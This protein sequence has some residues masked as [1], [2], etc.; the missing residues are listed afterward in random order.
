MSTSVRSG[1]AV[2]VVVLLGSVAACSK[3][4]DAPTTTAA[5]TTTSPVQPLST[6]PAGGDAVAASFPTAQGLPFTEPPILTSTN[7]VLELTLDARKGTYEVGGV[8]VQGM[9][10]TGSFMGP[11]LVITPGDTL[12]FTVINN[13]GQNTNV[14]EHGFHVSPIGISDNVLRVMAPGS[15]SPVVVETTKDLTPGTYWYHTHLHGLTEAQVMAGLFGTLVVNGLSERLPG[16]LQEGLQEHLVALH[17]YQL[18][19]NNEVV[20]ENIDSNAPTTRMVN[21]M[22]NPVLTS[23]PGQTKLLRLANFSADIWYRLQMDGAKFSVLAEDANPVGRVEPRATLLLPPGKRFDVLVTWPKAGSYKL[24]TLR[25][26]Q[27]PEGDQYPERVLMTVN[28]SGSAVTTPSQPSSLAALP[29]LQNAEVAERRTVVFS[30]DNQAGKFFINGKQFDGK[31]MYT[32]KLGTVEEW[33]LKNVTGEDH[34]FHIHVNDFQVMSVN[35]TPYAANSLQDIVKIPAKGEV[36][37]RQRF[38]DFLGSFVFHCHILA[39]EDN[40]MMAIVEVTT[41]GKAGPARS[42]TT[43]PPMSGM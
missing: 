26:N 38:A 8:K 15:T 4:G 32:P 12:K 3:A 31:V 40:G 6:T 34:P 18:T 2:A 10:Y 16:D 27:G 23:R 9:T 19:A 36:V 43:M 1:V 20:T 39:H 7:G 17:D 41:D 13:L 42:T 29:D 33:T 28:V 22:V 14:H 24:R 5:P 35:G 30:E 37:I 11:T 21:G 25:Y